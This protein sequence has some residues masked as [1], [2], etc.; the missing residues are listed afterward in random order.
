M[1]N[2]FPDAARKRKGLFLLCLPLVFMPF[3]A[4]LAWNFSPVSAS[5][6]LES[7][8]LN[9]ELPSPQLSPGKNS[10]SD[11]YQAAKKEENP[12]ADWPMPDF[13]NQSIVETVAVNSPY[14]Q[15][16]AI[17]TFRIPTQKAP[18]YH[19]KAGAGLGASEQEVM[20]QLKELESILSNSG[21]DRDA[22]NFQPVSFGNQAD[23]ELAQLRQMM[24]QMQEVSAQPDPEIQQLEGLM[25]KILQLQYPEK[26][27]QHALNEGSD[28]SPVPVFPEGAGETKTEFPDA[29]LN[30]Q[31]SYN[32]FFGLETV[33][34]EG[35][36]KRSAFRKTISATVGRTQEIIPG[37]AL[38]L[39][40]EEEL[41]VAD[42]V[43]PRGS[44]LHAKTSLD[45]SRLQVQISG[46]LQE[47]ALIPVSLM[48]Y[49]LDGI[50][51]IE[52]NDMKGASQWLR[53][54]AQSAQSLNIN[55][56]G[57]DWQSQLANTGIQ[58]TRS[59]LRNK[60]RVRRIEIKSGHPI[61]L[62]DSSTSKI[63]T[64]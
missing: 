55:S 46:I 18:V 15:E 57:M 49:G 61:L 64:L 26:Y 62:I 5:P 7:K 14:S 27:P 16:S 36:T 28:F 54:S 39:V 63:Q 42:Q 38:E 32:G 21:G 23:P 8:G 50:P 60:S 12:A 35:G 29:S 58:A 20:S 9:L 2:N 30:D 52:L 40:L 19:G 45:G 6:D 41:R 3:L 22:L 17:G 59:L 1:T 24:E 31:E 47:G 44:I 11:A 4:L 43:L 13:L 33:K 25:D 56:M 51:G 37:E 34:Q 53:S 48:G 10:K